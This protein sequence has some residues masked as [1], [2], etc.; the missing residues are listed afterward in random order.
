MYYFIRNRNKSE[1]SRSLLQLWHLLFVDR[2]FSVDMDSPDMD[3]PEP[4]VPGVG[5]GGLGLGSGSFGGSVPGGLSAGLS[6]GLGGPLGG[7]HWGRPTRLHNARRF[8]SRGSSRPDRSPAVEGWVW[9][10]YATV[11]VHCEWNA[12]VC[13]NF[14]QERF[15]SCWHWKEFLDQKV[16]IHGVYLLHLCDP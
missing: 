8:R 13:P 12:K 11:W 2:P 15:V 1:C 4:R 7:E 6:G 9:A 5:V 14:W 10:L 3:S 16:Q